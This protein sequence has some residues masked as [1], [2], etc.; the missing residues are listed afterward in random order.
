MN[1]RVCIL[2]ASIILMVFCSMP[3]QALDEPA[4][5]ILV[6]GKIITVNSQDLIA[7]A[8]AVKDGKIIKVG[9][10]REIKTLAGS[11]CKLI[12]WRG[13]TVTP[14]V[15]DSHY[16]VIYDGMQFWP[17]FVNIRVP[18]VQSKSDLLHIVGNKAK[19]LKKGE[20]ISANQGFHIKPDETLDR[21]DLDKVAPDN[22]A[23]LRHGS[24]QYAVV[25]TAALKI[26]GIDRNTPDPVSSKVMHDRSGEPNGVSSHYPA[27]NLVAQHAPG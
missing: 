12:D 11:P 18:A 16:H 14:G 9:S 27:E 5:L 19:Q 15:V 20:W 24:G 22:P 8:I 6:N 13:K 17:G 25:N 21:W 26:A 10:N 2:S 23:Y 4:D 1:T 7:E 3:L